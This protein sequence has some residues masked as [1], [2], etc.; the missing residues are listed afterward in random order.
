VSDTLNLSLIAQAA[1]VTDIDTERRIITGTV[2]PFGE[3]GRT[4]LG[5]R[6]VR[7]GA[8]QFTNP[9]DPL[10]LGTYGHGDEHGTERGPVVARMT[11]YEMSADRFRARFRVADGTL[12]DRLLAEADPRTGTRSMLSI[13]LDGTVIDLTTGDIVSGLCEYVAFVPIGAYA[14]ARVDSVAA[15]AHPLTGDS[16]TLAHRARF[17]RTLIEVGGGQPPAQQQAP[18]QQQQAP[19]PVHF[20]APQQQQAP[21]QQAP[22]QQA[23]AGT[24]PG[25]DLLA[26][27]G[28][29]W[30][31]QQFAQQAQQQGMPQQA[32]PPPAPVATLGASGGLPT[33]GMPQHAQ[34]AQPAPG[35]QPSAS[36]RS[37][38][39][40]LAGLRAA[41]HRGDESAVQNLR[42]A[43]ADIVS[44]GGAGNTGGNAD[45]TGLE[46]FQ[47][48]PGTIGQELWSG[49]SYTRRFVP[50]FTPKVLTS[51]KFGGWRWV[52]KP[53]LAAYSGNKDEVP[54]SGVKVE[55]VT[56]EAER[57]AGAWDIDRKFRDFGDADFWAGFYAGQT[58]SYLELS[59]QAAAA[60]LGG[61]ALDM[62]TDANRPTGYAGVTVAAGILPA[63]ALGQAMLEDTPNVRRPADFIGMNTGDWLSLTNVT[64]LDL[65]AFLA[66]LGV[67][68]EQFL[69]SN[70]FAAGKVTLGVTPAISF[71]ELGGG[72]PIRVEALDVAHAGIDS[73]AYGYYGTLL[74]RPG[75]VI[76][77][78]IG[79]VQ[80]GG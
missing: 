55:Y 10:V 68:P 56:D 60:A 33:Q 7:H 31:S 4:N 51:W 40:T 20:A 16:V 43:L 38:V 77:V 57:V 70:Q 18:Q 14:T 45:S 71:Y 35:T 42:A 15:S 59:D 65:P 74:N 48:P 78:P 13:E 6:A 75:G 24:A 66:L 72:S 41:M 47:G 62:G 27:V 8:V 22:Q 26:Q 67:R 32:P 53:K 17:G 69:R 30:L 29:W 58:E 1:Q 44:A 63:V 21:Q 64:N 79:T 12:G 80:A 2:V 3:R 34:H 19:Q 23:P 52:T 54:T 61:Y 36:P 11:A 5:L 76:S 28:G 37:A 49:A 39:R 25:G 50:L 73:G 46:L 9:S